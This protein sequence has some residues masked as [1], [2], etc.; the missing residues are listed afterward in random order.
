MRQVSGEAMSFVWKQIQSA[1]FPLILIAASIVS[2]GMPVYRYDFL[3]LVA[4]LA[5]IGLIASK[6]E[7]FR[8][9]AVTLVFHALGLA[10]E[11]FKVH[12][13][14]WEYPGESLTKIGGV[15][16]YSGFMYASI[17]SYVMQA[18]RRF[19]LEFENWPKTGLLAVLLTL[20]YL[21]FFTNRWILDCR[22]SIL[23]FARTRV[24]FT[25]VQAANGT[26]ATSRTMA[27]PLAFVFIGSFVWVTEH[28]C[29]FLGVWRYPDQHQ[30]WTW[31]G[32]SK[33]PS[34]WMMTIVGVS[35]VVKLAKLDAPV[36]NEARATS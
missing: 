35:L 20:V 16:V 26:L 19:C 3:L 23:L 31:V 18:K 9:F 15:P 30:V 33:L 12:H 8:E 24:R 11:L 29:T 14:S 1:T 17:A 7:T 28:L 27:M 4:I 10:L 34:W 22:F 36:R 32:I 13:G 6:W 25:T 2:S 5:Q 21:N